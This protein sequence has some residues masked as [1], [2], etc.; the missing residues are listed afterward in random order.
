[1]NGDKPSRLQNNKFC[2]VYLFLKCIHTAIYKRN[3]LLLYEIL[4][5]IFINDVESL[6]EVCVNAK[7][8]LCAFVF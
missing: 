3:G 8:R 6:L 4:H 5:F 2:W 7:Y 1:M